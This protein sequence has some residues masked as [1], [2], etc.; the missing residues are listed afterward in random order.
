VD[1]GIRLKGSK[2]SE[3]AISK[4]N[5]MDDQQLLRELTKLFCVERD[6]SVNW[7]WEQGLPLAEA[8]SPEVQTALL[9]Y[10]AREGIGNPF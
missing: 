10:R 6:G 1:T 5:N 8:A 7:M 2:P 3:S 4:D 9:V